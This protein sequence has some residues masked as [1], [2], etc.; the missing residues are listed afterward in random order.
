MPV[1]LKT[2]AYVKCD[3]GENGERKQKYMTESGM[4]CCPKHA[5]YQRR[6]NAKNKQSESDCAASKQ[7]V[8]D[9]L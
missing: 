3:L 1:T 2:C 5:Q 8:S 6:L 4:Y 7:G 9:E